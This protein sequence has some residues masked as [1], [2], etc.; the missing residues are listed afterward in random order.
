VTFPVPPGTAAAVAHTWRDRRKEAAYT[1][2]SGVRFKF[3]YRELARDTPLRTAIFSFPGINND[4]VQQN[5]FGSRAY[6]WECIFWGDQC[7]LLATAFEAALCEAGEGRLEHPLYGTF[8]VVPVG[9]IARRDNLKDEANKAT[10]SITFW[11]TTGAIYPSSSK[12][13]QSEILLAL[14]SF[15]VAAA[16]QFDQSMDLSS[17]AKQQNLLA[18]A[19]KLLK[20]ASDVLGEMAS[21][22]SSV[23][24]A[25]RD[26]E[27]TLNFSL[28]VLIGQPLQLAL[29]VSNLIKAPG[30]ALSGIGS[31]LDGY[32]ELAGRMFASPAGNPGETIGTSPS[33]LT[34]KASNDFHTADLFATSAVAGA[35]NA[36]VADPIGESTPTGTVNAQAHP[37]TERTFKTRPEAI[38]AAQQILTL[39]D[40]AVLWRDNGFQALGG[41]DRVGIGQVDTGEAYQALRNAAA[42]TAGH[43]IQTSFSLVPERSVVLTRR[44]TIVDLCAELYGSVDAKLDFLIESN[45]L[46]GDEILELQP[47]REILYYP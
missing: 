39:F 2:P 32:G 34:T 13:P 8:N 11:T 37:L 17:I 43:L 25:F 47:G 4:Y 41:V 38:A 44:R 5:G 31:R 45:N 35:I 27:S 10:V 24:N 21:A 9:T 15:D 28:D 26:L 20:E 30:R 1:S 23:N 3:E 7:D 42:L 12:N 6:P 18:T 36:A 33:K 29:A 14:G 22:V 16:Q 46:T 40:A 19:N